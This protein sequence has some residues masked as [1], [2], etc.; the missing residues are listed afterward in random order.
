M[1][2]QNGE[3]HPEKHLWRKAVHIFVCIVL[4]LPL[5]AYCWVGNYM[6]YSGDDYCY[7]ESLVEN[8]FIKNQVH[9]YLNP[10][11]FNGNRYSLTLFSNIGDLFGPVSSAVMPGLAILFWVAGIWLLFDEIG[12]L[13]QLK[14]VALLQ[15]ILAAFTVF[16]TLYQAPF[17]MQNLYWRA[18][19]LTYLAPVICLTWL[20]WFS[21]F[22]SN[23]E[24]GMVFLVPGICILAFFSAGF[25]ETGAALQAATMMFALAGFEVHRRMDFKYRNR[26]LR[27][28]GLA[29]LFVLLA[30]LVLAFSP[31]NANRIK[32]YPHPD[33][34][35]LVT[36]SLTYA[37][38]FIFESLRSYPLPSLVTVVFS[39][40]LSLDCSASS[41]T[42]KIKLRKWLLAAGLIILVCFTLIA[43]TVAPSV[44]A[45]TAY[46]E[47][48]TWMPG[49]FAMTAGLVALGLLIGLFVNKLA[50]VGNKVKE[51][52]I[53]VV[54][55][56]T[57]A[58][59]LRTVPRILENIRPFRSW[60]AAWDVRDKAIR[61][62]IDNGEMDLRVNELPMIIPYVS[63]LK[64]DPGYW[65]NACAAGW[66]GVDTITAVESP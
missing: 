7:G 13:L 8:G 52:V 33:L 66:Y 56:A 51:V 1:K 6:R 23:K 12:K 38:T 5:V 40:A 49:R 34:I 29:L 9:S 15:L 18:A 57:C 16:I 45:R 17:L 3:G 21:L 37:L 2:I 39:A 46:P 59:V 41:V 31:S 54:F 35:N 53:L 44:L 64:A 26:A 27:A 11:P 55:L 14:R 30:M 36:L 65:Y 20:L 32:D 19:M 42:G 10:M 47:Q 60:A 28:F 63:E 62:A 22:Y 48:R 61:Y 50:V 25:S 43:A 24:R 58:Y 4:L